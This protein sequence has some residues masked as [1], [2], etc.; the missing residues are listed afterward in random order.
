MYLRSKHE[1]EF[2]ST[3]L[4][5]IVY[6]QNFALRPPAK[7]RNSRMGERL[8]YALSRKLG[9]SLSASLKDPIIALGLKSFFG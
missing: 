3:P 6:C 9:S 4:P 1:G 7:Q 2:R 8:L 5:E